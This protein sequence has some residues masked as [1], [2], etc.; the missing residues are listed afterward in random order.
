MAVESTKKRKGTALLAVMDENC[1]S[2]AGSPLC[3]LHCPVEDC[4]NL[5]YEE[6]PQGGLKPYRVWV[7]NDKC[8]GCQMCY[9]DDLTKVHQHKETGEVYYEYA[10]RFYDSSRKPLE[11]DKM[12][13]KFQL[14]LIGTESEDR[15][16]KKICPWDAIKMYEFD[17][18][19]AVAQYFYDAEKIKTVNG[20]YVIDPEEKERLE[21][22]QQE[23]Y[24]G[25]I[26]AGQD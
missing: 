14:Q 22:I 24:G 18:G 20:L 7:D 1:S 15:L 9:S 2:C 8:I 6:V 26:A 13:K 16:D 12:P 11:P 10:G 25:K 3:E 5:L 4:I 21:K 19:L 23:L 17:E